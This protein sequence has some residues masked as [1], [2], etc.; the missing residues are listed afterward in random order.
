[1]QEQLPISQAEPSGKLPTRASSRPRRGIVGT[2]LYWAPVWAAGLVF[3]QLALLGMRPARQERARLELET[4]R[5]NQR[6]AALLEQREGLGLDLRRLSDEIYR[7]R[8]RRSGRH[9]QPLTLQAARAQT[10]PEPG[11]GQ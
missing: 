11:Q 10:R 8:V 1:M 2:V 6:V 7:E 9:G 5:M 3:A 4:A